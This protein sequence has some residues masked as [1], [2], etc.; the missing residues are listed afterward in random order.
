MNHYLPFEKA[1][2]VL[3]ARAAE[4]RNS[5][6]SSAG[7]FDAQNEPI[8]LD[9]KADGNV[10]ITQPGATISGRGLEAQLDVQR[11]TLKSEVRAQ[12]A[13]SIR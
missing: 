10:T 12:Y 2:E 4:L 3:E 5:G 13:S 7:G 11:V 8:G 6:D 9:F 1:I